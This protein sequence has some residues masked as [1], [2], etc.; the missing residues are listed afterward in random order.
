MTDPLDREGTP[1]TAVTIEEQLARD[2]F[3]VSTTVGSSMR[4]MLR[5]R[6]DRVIVRALPA[7][8]RLKRFD[9]PLYRRADGKYVLHRVLG[10]RDGY[11]RIRGDNTF[12]VEKVPD[13][14]ILGRVTEFYR[15]DRH[16]TENSRFYRAYVRFWTFIYPVRWVFHL[17][18]AAAGKCRRLLFGRR[19]ENEN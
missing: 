14:Q 12:V 4:P 5:N 10:V 15:G 3:Y 1:P 8:E 18:R 17:L 9:L 13:G 7:G 6:R 16:V 2:G 19:K 11:Y